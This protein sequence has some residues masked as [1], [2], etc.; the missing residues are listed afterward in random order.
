[1]TTRNEAATVGYL[2]RALLAT[3]AERVVVVDAASE[4]DTVQCA[5]EAGATVVP[6]DV[7]LPIGPALMKAWQVALGAGAT[8]ILQIDAGGSHDPMDAARLLGRLSYA[9][10]VVGSRFVDGAEYLGGMWWRKAGSRWAAQMCNL[11]QGERL[12]DW[13]SGYRAFRA[14]VARD[15]L[16]YSYQARMHGWQIET[17]VHALDLNYRVTEAPI[18]YRAGRSSFDKKVAAE[19]FGVWRWMCNDHT[20]PVPAAAVGGER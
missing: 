7:R 13:T 14:G 18:T 16:R 17:L 12:T 9:D 2:V 10:L 5:A 4:D 15:L 11:V 8:A 3:V 1:V 20:R 19:A 6:S